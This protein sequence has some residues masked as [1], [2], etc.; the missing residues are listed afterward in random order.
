MICLLL[1]Y[2]NPEPSLEPVGDRLEESPLPMIWTTDFSTFVNN[3]GRVKSFALT[4]IGIATRPIWNASLF[5]DKFLKGKLFPKNK[6]NSL[7]IIKEPWSLN[8]IYVKVEAAPIETN[9]IITTM[10]FLKVK[11]N[12]F[13]FWLFYWCW[14]FNS[15]FFLLLPFCFTSW[16]PI[17]LLPPLLANKSIGSIT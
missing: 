7:S 5:K 6:D 12:A 1:S 15:L 11:L 13:M 3:S 17:I 10:I 16:V 14:F 9:T 4:G 8:L 2:T